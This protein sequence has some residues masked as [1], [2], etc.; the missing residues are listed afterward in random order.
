MKKLLIGLLSGI[1]LGLLFAPKEG[2]KLRASLSKSDE[3]LSDFGKEVLAAAKDA[4]SEVE[5]FI[6]S[7]EVQAILKKGKANISEIIKEGEKL[8]TKG[9]KELEKIITRVKSG[10]SE[11]IKAVKN[12]FEKGGKKGER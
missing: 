5:K 7:E 6:K 11:V 12:F 1:T 4:G 2:K 9:K 8:S 10:D 3:K